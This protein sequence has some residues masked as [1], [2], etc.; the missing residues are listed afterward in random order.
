MG[1]EMGEREMIEEGKQQRKR[2]QNKEG[3]DGEEK[4]RKISRCALSVLNFV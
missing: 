1:L 2:G 3:R 4:D